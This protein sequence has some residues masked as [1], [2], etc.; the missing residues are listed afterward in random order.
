LS[1]RSALEFRP[2]SSGDLFLTGSYSRNIELPGVKIKITKGPGALK[3]DYPFSGD[4][5]V[6]KQEGLYL[7][8]YNP[9]KK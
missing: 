4:L 8:T 5:V 9:V 6:S 2:T 1:H 3:G 7:K